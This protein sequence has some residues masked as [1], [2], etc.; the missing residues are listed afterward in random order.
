MFVK[1]I[2]SKINF[3]K[4][5]FIIGID[6]PTASGKTYLADRLVRAL[7]KE[8]ITSFVYRLDWRL[9]ERRLRENEA[10]I[11]VGN[12]S[13][14]QYEAGY[15]MD[16][17]PAFDFMNYFTSNFADG[18]E[19]K[20]T[21]LYN[22]ASGGKCDG[23][24]E[25]V[26]RE[27]MVLIIE[28]HYTHL[29]DFNRHIDYNL[30]LLAQPSELLKRKTE[31]AGSYRNDHK[32]AEYFRYVDMP[33]FYH[34]SEMHF[35]AFDNVADNTNY[36]SPVFCTKEEIIPFLKLF[37][38]DTGFEKLT[39][40]SDFF[41]LS[42]LR[43]IKLQE[44]LKN[45]LEKLFDFD[46]EAAKLY[47]LAEV[48]RQKSF[49]Q[50]LK[51]ILE[52]LN[53]RL[54]YCDFK[55]L[56]SDNPEYFLG[57][58]LDGIKV[59]FQADKFKI[60]IVL[61]LH[62]TRKVYEL[63]RV[64]AD[65]SFKIDVNELNY[66]KLKVSVSDNNK[67]LVP[68]SVFLNNKLS[69]E[70]TD[71]IFTENS[72]PVIFFDDILNTNFC[73]LYRC[74]TE[75]ELKF[76]NDIFN[77]LGFYIR[78]NGLFILVT[79]DSVKDFCKSLFQTELFSVECQHDNQIP[80]AEYNQSLN[81]IGLEFKD[82]II[83]GELNSARGFKNLFVDADYYH[84]KLLMNW[85]LKNHGDKLIF[86]KL[87]LKRL[88]N[89]LPSY[90]S[91]FYF[92]L[93]LRESS[94]IPF[95]TCYDL[96]DYSLDI[97]SYFKIGS[98]ENTAFGIQVSQ[99]AIDYDDGY[100]QVEEPSFFAQKLEKN[101]IYFLIKNPEKSLPLWSAGI[102][103]ASS[104]KDKPEGKTK[105]FISNALSYAYVNS[106]CLD[107]ESL[108]DKSD[109]NLSRVK[110]LLTDW[111]D[112]IPKD[113]EIEI[114]TGEKI[115]LLSYG[116]FEKIS[117]LIYNGLCEK[118]F[119]NSRFLLGPA[120]G[121]LHHRESANCSPHVSKEIF[122]KTVKSSCVGNVLHGTSFTSNDDISEFVN[123]HCIR[124]N[125][126]GQY[127][128]R[129][130]KSFPENILNEFGNNQTDRKIAFSR[131]EKLLQEFTEDDYKKTYSEI[132]KLFIDHKEVMKMISLSDNELEYFKDPVLK[133]SDKIL[134]I[135]C[136][137]CLM[138]VKDSKN[139]N[140][141]DI[142][143]FAS[144]I[145][146]PDSEFKN[147]LAYRV[148]NAGIRYFHIDVGDGI[149]IQREIS[150]IEKIKYLKEKFGDIKIHAHLMAK[151][152]ADDYSLIE[153]YCE[154][155]VDVL[156]VYNDSFN[157]IHNLEFAL[158]LIKSLSV[159][160]GLIVKHDEDYMEAKFD[161]I[162]SCDIHNIMFMGVESGRGGQKFNTNV[163]KSIREY[164]S[165]ATNQNYQLLIEVDG[166]L[167]E[168]IA[169][170]CKNAGAD[171]LSGWSYFMIHGEDNLEKTI[172]NLLHKI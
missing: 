112:S 72:N 74:N 139:D 131:S 23:A 148:Y 141:Q 159:K 2:L 149:Y 42:E 4:P 102:D 9:I 156:Y 35:T 115:N 25:F 13:K 153:K 66:K 150:G 152:T 160:P 70:Q 54:L 161:F 121:T 85:L 101:L 103:H 79:N 18:R 50:L 63:D 67:L 163:F 46:I 59:I 120:L 65:F 57:I 95:F 116:D 31:R 167:T 83:T 27:K 5:Y 73:F 94:A 123:Q 118:G 41:S 44:K 11:F 8:G 80:I 91:D 155:G 165:K 143:L 146:V 135:I 81:K 49:E 82:G 137:K 90:L 7:D 128:N 58:D 164:R 6:G 62:F 12:N 32:I 97:S 24:S 53:V 34:Y 109:G 3:A 16:M 144:M 33:S 47:G 55:D 124:V 96:R 168:K 105:R 17:K 89:N 71:I 43:N 39:I 68:N 138:D 133:L 158:N 52:N 147:N 104:Q 56:Y 125:F 38:N 162:K 84:R 37:N 119:I 142:D 40:T 1:H 48:S 78:R 45:L 64:F 20:L 106:V 166:G 87:S 117:N 129:M 36:N 28:G 19:I 98:E 69:L 132:R 114:V 93:S 110:A 107:F 51:D 29:P 136:E 169:F 75:V 157:N 127:L 22:R 108:L 92:A 130:V 26:M 99:N 122:D 151:F 100:L 15:H 30:L 21:N 111:L 134:D 126:A 154:V 60:R 10:D 86:D 76:W 77:F 14:F 61:L 170:E 172:Q 171:F 113:A 88:V 140:P 145:E